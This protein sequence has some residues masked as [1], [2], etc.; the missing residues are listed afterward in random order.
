MGKHDS[1]VQL[2]KRRAEQWEEAQSKAQQARFKRLCNMDIRGQLQQMIG[3]EVQFHG[4]QELV[5][6]AIMQGELPIIQITGTG[7]SKSLS[8][9]LP[10]FCLQ[11]RVMIMVVLLVV[12]KG[13]LLC[14]YKEAQI[15]V[16][17]W[18]A[19]KAAQAASIILVTPES[20]TTKGFWEFINQLQA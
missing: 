16:E 9:M 7:G 4:I 5:I 11:G 17:V 18:A 3:K 14:Q 8:F 6:Q 10:A 13:D 12:L 2:G 19:G 15:N 20:A 1:N